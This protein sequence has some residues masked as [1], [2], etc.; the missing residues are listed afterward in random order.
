[1]CTTPVRHR[2]KEHRCSATE[3]NCAAGK[4]HRLLTATNILA[5]P[6]LGA[7]IC[8]V[9]GISCLV[10]WMQADSNPV[11]SVHECIGGRL[12]NTISIAS[13]GLDKLEPSRMMTDPENDWWLSICRR[14]ANCCSK[15]DKVCSVRR[16]AKP[17]PR[18]FL[19]FDPSNPPSEDMYVACSVREVVRVHPTPRQD[20]RNNG[21][22]QAAACLGSTLLHILIIRH[23]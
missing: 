15:L 21:Q 22:K 5:L 18:L 14:L 11:W 17:A 3:S 19:L 20:N 2:F 8:D 1:M 6:V 4:R 16:R 10:D 9:R 23:W 12:G 7:G 13:R